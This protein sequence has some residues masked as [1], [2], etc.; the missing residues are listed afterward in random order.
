MTMQQSLGENLAGRFETIPVSHWSFPEMVAGFDFDVD[1][2][3]FYGGYPGAALFAGTFPLWHDIVC[4]RRPGW[5][6]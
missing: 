2:Y 4:R 5:T 3:V 6:G 1:R